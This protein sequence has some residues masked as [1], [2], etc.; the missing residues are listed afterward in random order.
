[1]AA[2]HP[3]RR[4]RRTPAAPIPHLAPP[5]HRA[6][7]IETPAHLD[8]LLASSLT[9]ELAPLRARLDHRFDHP[10]Y[11]VEAVRTYDSDAIQHAMRHVVGEARAWLAPWHP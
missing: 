6:E 2:W 11:L 1:M 9:V 8:A 7:T 3:A 10:G 4:P 5:A